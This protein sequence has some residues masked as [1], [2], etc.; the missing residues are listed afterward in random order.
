MLIKQ[1]YTNTKD[2]GPTV[3]FMFSLSGKSKG[4]NVNI[5]SRLTNKNLNNQKAMFF[6]SSLVFVYTSAFGTLNLSVFSC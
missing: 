6:S 2:Y 1:S 5:Q 3:S 4:K